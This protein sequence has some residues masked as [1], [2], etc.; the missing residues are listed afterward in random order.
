M[1][2]SLF[3]A[4]TV[5]EIAERL[6]PLHHVELATARIKY[7][8]QEKAGKKGGKPLLGKAQ[9]VSGVLEHFADCDFLL[10][11][12]QDTWDPLEQGKRIALVDHLLECCTGEESDKDPSAAIVWR[13]REPD[14]REFGTILS[15]HGA[16]SEDLESFCTIAQS[17]ISDE[18][19]TV[20]PHVRN[21]AES[22]DEGLA[23]SNRRSY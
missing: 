22:S 4:E 7:L 15:R 11:V 19:E 3:N 2:Q 21:V 13:T 23:F 16:W 14:V 8:F 12:A 17:M 18:I 6:I 10:V 9:K 20:Q 1:P 5:Q